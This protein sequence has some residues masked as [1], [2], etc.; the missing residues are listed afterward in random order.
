MPKTIVLLLGVLLIVAGAVALAYHSFSYTTQE[1]VAEI[2]PF[3]ATVEHEKTVIIPWAI[4]GVLVAGGVVLVVVGVR[5][6]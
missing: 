2:G 3:K 4:G 6:K 1:K 5:S